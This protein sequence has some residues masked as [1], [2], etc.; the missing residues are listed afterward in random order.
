MFPVLFLTTMVAV[1]SRLLVLALGP[2]RAVEP[3]LAQLDVPGRPPRGPLPDRSDRDGGGIGDGDGRARLRTTTIERSIDATLQAKA[4]VFVGSDVV[5]RVPPDEPIPAA[6]AERST[7]VDFYIGAWVDLARREQVNVYAIDPTSFAHAA[8]WDDSLASVPLEEILER[9]EAPPSG[10]RVPALVVGLDI[11]AVAEAGI[12]TGG[13]D[14]LRDRRGG[15][16]AGVP[17]HAAGE[18]GHVRRRLHAGGPRPEHPVPRD[19]DCSR[20][21]I[22]STLDEARTSYEE[23]TTADHVVDAVSFLTVSQTFG[24]MRSLAVASALLVVGGVAVYFDRAPPEPGARLCVRPSHG[25]HEAPAQASAPGRGAGGRGRRLLAGGR[26]RPGWCRP[27]APA[28]RP[29]PVGP[30]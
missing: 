3:R 21:E 9:L 23:T 22:L 25:P 27:G 26:R 28:A 24:F 10:G 30:T 8:F 18:P 17:G 14:S 19:L 15:R 20:A 11:P 5:V 16:G 2:L 29:A 13:H 1:V 7:G 6:L 12:I 4:H